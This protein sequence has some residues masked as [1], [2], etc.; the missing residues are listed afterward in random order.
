MIRFVRPACRRLWHSPLSTKMLVL[1]LLLLSACS[2]IECPVQNTVYTVYKIT[3]GTEVV[4]TLK[5]TISVWSVRNNGT[6]TL[7]LYNRGTALTSFN[8]PI[9]YSCPED[10]L[11]FL[12]WKGAF[13]SLDTVWI[14]KEDIPHFESVDCNA[15]FFHEITAVRTTH[16]GIDTLIINKRTVD[17]DPRT[18]HFYIRFKAHD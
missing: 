3:D 17:Y 8:L 10:T 1:G 5:D 12:L 7:F 9:S 4:D 15:S 11:F 13:A 14:K 16:H 2:S 6:D 18:A